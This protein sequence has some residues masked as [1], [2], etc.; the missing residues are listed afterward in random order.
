M[1]KL[2]EAITHYEDVAKENFRDG[3]ETM[4]KEHTQVVEWLKELIWYRY[5][6]DWSYHEWLDTDPFAEDWYSN[7]KKV[8]GTR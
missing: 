7:W 2:E 8:Y 6:Y 4:G 5:R 1:W 3:W